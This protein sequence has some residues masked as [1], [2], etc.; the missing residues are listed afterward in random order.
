MSS[1]NGLQIRLALPRADF[2]LEVDLSLPA[3]GVT[4]LYGPSG[5]GKTSV[6]RC[7]AGLE[8]ALPAHVSVAGETWQDGQTF[9]PPHRRA[10]G[11]VFQE[12]SLFEHLDVLGN[13]RYGLVRVSR[14]GG[15][16]GA[17]R[18]LDEAVQL[19]GIGHL[20]HRRV[21]SL[22]GGERQRVAIAR[23]L[24][25]APK[26]LLLD[27]PL[28]ALDAARKQDI[29]PWLE[30][31][32]DELRIPMIYVTHSTAE[33][34]RLGDHLV[35]LERGRVKAQGRVEDVLPAIDEPVFTGAEVAA[36]LRR[37]GE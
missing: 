10:L 16:R 20:L 23:A 21:Q 15:A 27:E 8:R 31:M 9:V 24:A 36:L 28:A 11:Y 22:S 14:Q 35:V 18:T 13:L 2:T 5:A 12:A 33:L 3:A 37:Q 19:L 25:T 7:V 1:P 6:L 29:L 26:L 17:E 32:R 4:V 34:A 30:R